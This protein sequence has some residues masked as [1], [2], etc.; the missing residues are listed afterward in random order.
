M[1]YK[2]DTV[3][4]LF[5]TVIETESLSMATALAKTVAREIPGLKITML[6]NGRP[7]RHYIGKV[8]ETVEVTQVIGG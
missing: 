6:R 1:I 4:G 7:F 2:V 5:S 3:H 8:R